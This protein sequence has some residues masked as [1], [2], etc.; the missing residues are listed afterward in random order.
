MAATTVVVDEELEVDVDAIVEEVELEA[1]LEELVV[2]VEAIVDEELEEL[3]VEVDDVLTDED[4][5]DEDDEDDVL[6]VLLLVEQGP[7]FSR[8]LAGA[9]RAR[10]AT[11]EAAKI[12][13][14]RIVRN[15]EIALIDWLLIVDVDC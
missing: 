6:V 11:K 8:S 14:K 1:E 9:A 13:V 15:R 2:E 5:D 4:E 7:R 3:I 12:S 10:P